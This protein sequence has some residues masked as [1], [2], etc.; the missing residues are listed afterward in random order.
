MTDEPTLTDEQIQTV[1]AQGGADVPAVS[2]D[3][4][5]TDSDSRDTTDSSDSGDSSDSPRR[6][7]G[8]PSSAA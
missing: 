3:D 5:T 7:G 4:D 2:D 6:A 8:R 1:R